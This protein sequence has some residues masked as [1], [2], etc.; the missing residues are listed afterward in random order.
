MG[1][2]NALIEH[3]RGDTILSKQSEA[4]EKQGWLKHGPACGNCQS[5]TWEDKTVDYGPCYGLHVLEINLRCKEGEFKTGKSSWCR[6]HEWRE[7]G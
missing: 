1:K 2:K 7:G 6:W 3:T 4:K 5:F